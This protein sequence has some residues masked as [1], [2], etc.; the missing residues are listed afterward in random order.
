MGEAKLELTTAAILREGEGLVGG[1][2]K[3]RNVEI[4]NNGLFFCTEKAANEQGSNGRDDSM[5]NSSIRW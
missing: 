1:A 4:V 5:I 2:V 3:C